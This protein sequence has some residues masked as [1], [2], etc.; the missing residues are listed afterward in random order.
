MNDTRKTKNRLI[1]E[2]NAMRVRL[3]ALEGKSGSSSETPDSFPERIVAIAEMPQALANV[4][5]TE[6]VCRMALEIAVNRLGL[7]AL[8]IWVRSDEVS[9]GVE[10]VFGLDAD[11]TPRDMRGLKH[12]VDPDSVCARILA[13]AD[14]ISLLEDSL[15]EAIPG[16]RKSIRSRAFASLWDGLKVVGYVRMDRRYSQPA[17]GESE[18]VVLRLFAA[19][20]GYLLTKKRAEREREWTIE[21]L[22]DAMARIKTLSG[23]LPI[24]AACKKIR[25]EAG[26]WI[27][28]EDFIESHCDVLFSHSIC[29]ECSKR[30]YPEVYG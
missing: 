8:E 21:E 30:L 26:A 18:V 29:P 28:L 7:S 12:R 6:D 11:G 25:D 17:I 10:G 4:R 16:S 3:A 24:C 20:L 14:S 2:L 27:R 1:E 9:D 5:D 23:Q 22:Q 15:P 19:M 13:S